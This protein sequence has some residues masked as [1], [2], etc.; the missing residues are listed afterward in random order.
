MEYYPEKDVIKDFDHT[1]RYSMIM[2]SDFGLI[3]G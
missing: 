1:F 3:L 2:W